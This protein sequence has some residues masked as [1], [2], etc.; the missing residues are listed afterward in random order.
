M[1]DSN[2]YASNALP[3]V[4]K[5][6]SGKIH[7]FVIG[8]VALVVFACIW[9]VVIRL[10]NWTFAN[11]PINLP[12]FFSV[13]IA[14]TI[15]IAR[16]IVNGHLRD[17]E[18]I[19]ELTNMNDTEKI[20]TAS[21]LQSHGKLYLLTG[22]ATVVG[23]F[24]AW[25]GNG[26][27]YRLVTGIGK[28]TYFEIWMTFLI[29]LIWV[30]ITQACTVFVRNLKLFAAIIRKTEIN[31]LHTEELTVFLLTGI[32]STL[33]FAGTYAL[34]P[35]I[36]ISSFRDMFFNPAILIFIPLILAMILIPLMP[37]RKKIK[38]A[39]QKELQLINQAIDGDRSS[40]QHSLIADSATGLNI[41]DLI[42]YKKIISKTS[43]IPFNVPTAFRLL[44]YIIIPL[45][46]WVAASL[47][48]KIVV[49][50]LQA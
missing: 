7:H 48:D 40:L 4:L 10:E 29:I 28:Y 16:V 1:S 23:L 13:T 31:L 6:S 26:V 36:G 8:L 50:I 19:K 45:L 15:F 17:F 12:A 49:A 47:V 11:M 41:I 27:L 38:E 35:L 21:E 14:Y 22:I 46:T 24:H 30:V 37:L 18:K 44:L 3:L 32:R 2:G 20:R 25:L 43:E 42:N 39:K 33:A 5:I 34:F 9:A